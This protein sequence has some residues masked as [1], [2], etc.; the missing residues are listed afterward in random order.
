VAKRDAEATQQAL[1]ELFARVQEE[2]AS[3][4]DTAVRAWALQ[5]GK[6]PEEWLELWRPVVR[7]EGDSRACLLKIEVRAEAIPSRPTKG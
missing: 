7:L 2:L 4:V 3:V 5:L 6:T 1:D